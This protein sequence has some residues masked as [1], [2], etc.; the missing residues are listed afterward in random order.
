MA[1]IMSWKCT[2]VAATSCTALQ[3][4]AQTAPLTVADAECVAK[5]VEQCHGL[6]TYGIPNAFSTPIVGNLR[7][8]S[9]PPLKSLFGSDYPRPPL[10]TD[11]LLIAA[12]PP[13]A[14]MRTFP[15][16][17]LDAVKDVKAAQDGAAAQMV[18]VINTFVRQSQ[19]T[20]DLL[21]QLKDQLDAQQ[22]LIDQLTKKK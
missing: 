14:C 1:K 7:D 22:K 18:T 16:D 15:S 8:A 12:A 3:V 10:K 6:V 5:A 11:C 19:A 20:Q 13:A 4:M 21:R 2:L 17:V 9:L